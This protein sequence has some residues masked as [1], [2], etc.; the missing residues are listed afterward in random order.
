[1]VFNEM[2]LVGTIARAHGLRGQ[3]IVNP[4]TDFPAERF[5]AGAELFVERSG[6][7]EPL[8]VTSVRFQQDRPVIGLEG[9]D[10]IDDAEQLAGLELRVPRERLMA[11]PA[12]TYYR[13][14][15]IGCRV[16][17][18][19]GA[20]VGVVRDVDATGGGSR[21]VV[22]GGGGKILIPLAD[23]ICTIVDIDHK[24]IVVDAPEGLLDLNT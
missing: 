13:H 3:V 15:L 5:Q 8:R 4:E 20:A 2:A 12:G 6:S 9:I 22:D 7:V 24:R 16:E 21:L 10:S 1:M 23:E 18:S 14:D 11:L 17:K 19:D